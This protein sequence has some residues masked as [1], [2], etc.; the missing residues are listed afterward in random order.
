L[1]GN[2]SASVVNSRSDDLRFAECSRLGLLLYPPR[3]RWGDAEF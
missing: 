1:D 3:L 2:A